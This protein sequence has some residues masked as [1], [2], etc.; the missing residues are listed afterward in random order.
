MEIT[1]RMRLSAMMFLEFFIWGAWSVTMGT[2]LNEIGFQGTE[3]SRAYST[4]AWAAIL[5][6][7][8]VGLVADRYFAAQKVMG[9][10]HLL[11]AALLYY[12]STVTDAGFFFWVLLGYALCYM[13]TL[14][15]V[16]AISFYQMKEPEKEFPSIRVL[17]TIGWIVAGIIISTMEGFGLEGIEATSTPMR[18]AAGASA[19]LALYSFSLPHTPP[20]SAGKSVSVAEVLGLDALRLMKERPFAVF[21][22]SS[23]LISIPLAFYYNF[24]N[25]FLNESGMQ[26]VA[27]KMTLGQGSEIVFMLV[28][29]FFFRRLGVKYMLLVGMLAWTARYVLFAF[30]NN[31]ALVWMLYLGIILHGVCYDFF[32]VTG[33]IYVDKKAPPGLRSSAQGFI[34]LITY[35]VGMVIGAWVSGRI[36]Q[37]NEVLLNGEVSG[38]QWTD[39]WIQPAIMAGAVAAAFALLF[40]EK[41]IRG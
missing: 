25:L 2:Y 18:L 32:F 36:V 21:I 26:A 24:T 37:G 1:L 34:T 11:G 27:A 4:T 29:P 17:G 35:G 10:L 30:G 20:A 6:P 15:L 19:L 39:I 28:M 9:V 13:P 16:N 12:A 3:I 5:S 23:L 41:R 33:Q 14:A 38:H 8:F 7:F 22:V 31:D 40:N